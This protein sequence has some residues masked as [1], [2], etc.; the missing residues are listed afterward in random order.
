MDTGLF[1]ELKY[2]MDTKI[3]GESVLSGCGKLSGGCTGQSLICT[4]VWS[5]LDRGKPGH[6]LR[7]FESEDP[8]GECPVWVWQA[9]WWLYRAILDLHCGL[10]Q[11]GQGKTWSSVEDV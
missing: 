5:N 11:F 4:V 3:T 2:M 1:I 8:R 10:E 7:M 6:W 9:F